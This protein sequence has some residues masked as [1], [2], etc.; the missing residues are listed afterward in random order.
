MFLLNFKFNT[1]LIEPLGKLG[2]KTILSP[3]HLVKETQN[4]KKYR[5]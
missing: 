5:K 1:S 3:Y 4:E 2:A